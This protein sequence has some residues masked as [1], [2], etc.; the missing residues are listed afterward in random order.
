MNRPFEFMFRIG[1]EECS[2]HFIKENKEVYRILKDYQEEEKEIKKLMSW[3]TIMNRLTSFLENQRDSLNDY[4]LTSEIPEVVYNY[5]DET[6]L[7]NY[8]KIYP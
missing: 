7:V 1:N 8:A 3:V 4:F 5:L 2:G 6:Y